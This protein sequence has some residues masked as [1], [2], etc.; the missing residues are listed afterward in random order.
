M[1]N[2][3][4]LIFLSVSFLLAFTGCTRMKVKMGW[5]VFLEK[6]PVTSIQATLPKGPGIA[7][8]EKSPL[9]V[10][11]TQPDGKVLQTEG[12]GQGPVMWNQITVAS[13]VVDA[14][15][16]GLLSLPLDPRITEGKTGHVVISVASHPDLHA[17]LDVPIRYDYKYFLDF[18]G[19]KGMSGTSGMNGLDGSSGSSGSMDPNNPS[20]GGNGGDGS[21]GGNGG[22]GSRGGDGQPVIIRVA[23]K[24]A[25]NPLLQIG[26]SSRA[27]ESFYMID[28][29]GGSLTVLSNGGDGGSGGRG[30]RGGR[31]GSGGIGSPS[32][33]SG[34]DGL[35]GH[36]G[37]NGSSGSGGTITVIYDP[38]AK[39][40][41]AAIHLMNHGGPRPQFREMQ[42][43]QLW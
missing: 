34:R 13:T 32:G 2:T 19:S 25:S 40:Y 17:E 35:N 42:I 23:L 38:A 6:T 4:W 43:G 22:D 27:R 20:A 14:N 11:F 29:Q 9:V 26:V 5:K 24:Q 8:G 21:N 10:A 3:R 33:S 7:P 15:N 41:L 30:G 39:P 37:S 1:F 16:K 18:S 28:P 31:G 12:E 36:D